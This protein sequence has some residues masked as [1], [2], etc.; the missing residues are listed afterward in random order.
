[1]ERSDFHRIDAFLAV[2]EHRS[3]RDAARRRGTSPSALSQ[4]VKQLEDR[5]GVRLFNRTTR[6]VTLTD[7][8]QRL[9]EEARPALDT[10]AGALAQ[11]SGLRDRPAGRLR[12]NSAKS[13]ALLLLAP[14]LRDYLARYPD[15]EL[16]IATDDRMVDIVAEGFDA[17]L[18]TGDAVPRDMIAVP[19]GPPFRFAIAGTP[20]YFAAHGR[21]AVPLDLLH[22]ACLRFRF[23]S[24]AIFRWDFEKAGEAVVVDIAGPL[25]A[26][27]RAL[28]IAAALDGVGLICMPETTLQEHID[29]GRLETVLQDWCPPQLPP[30]LYYPGHRHVAPALQA[31]I[32]MVR[33]REG[34]AAV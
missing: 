24:G 27:D 31:L 8:G 1:M 18:R 7:A 12:I 15:V 29:A 16:E 22:H 9:L 17:G 30:M 26:N 3:F 11:A 19:L 28:L 5:L 20:A 23:A 14:V 32:R 10:L 33:Y 6:S 25:I 2:A 34:S 4:A 13:A 21:P